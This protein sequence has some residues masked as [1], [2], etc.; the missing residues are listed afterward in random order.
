MLRSVSGSR[1]AQMI[2]ALTKKKW[3]IPGSQKQ[4]LSRS[5][6][7]QWLKE[8]EECTKVE[9][10][11]LDA[12]RRDKG[13]FPSLSKPQKESLLVW[14]NQN[15]YRTVIQLREELL[16]HPETSDNVPST[17]TISRY[18]RAMGYSRQQ[19]LQTTE[20][21]PTKVRLSFE[22]DYPQQL[23]QADT[24]G[25]KVKVPNPDNPNE[26]IYATPIVIV[27]DHSRFCVAVHY[28]V[29]ENEE[30]VIRAVWEAIATYG[31]PETLY[32]DLGGPYR[33]E[34]LKQSL[35]LLGCIVKPTEADSPESK[36]KVEKLMPI[37]SNH[38]ESELLLQGQSLTLEELNEQAQALIHQEYHKTVHGATKETP[39][40]RFFSLPD[41]YRRFVSSKTLSLIFLPHKTAKVSKVGLITFKNQKY[42]VPNSSLYNKTVVIRY[43]PHNLQTI[44]VWYEDTLYGEASITHVHN[45]FRQKQA[46]IEQM[47]QTP[48]SPTLP[49]IS[50]VPMYGRMQ[51]RLAAHRQGLEEEHTNIELQKSKEERGTL[52]K[53]LTVKA[54]VKPQ[55]FDP[56][57]ADACVFLFETILRY[58]LSPSQRT[59]ILA[60]WRRYGPFTEQA[61]R[62][63]LATLL[64]TS[65]PVFDIEAY[66]QELITQKEDNLEKGE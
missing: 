64:A 51:R 53:E 44:F 58:T 46:M 28:V 1:R 14:R 61:V 24:K 12:Q 23:W 17:S 20:Q 45:D 33:G 35:L 13:T 39:E 7:Y 4:T 49:S 62:T 52:K 40:E 47:K 42:L 55:Q 3:T 57:N 60:A 37:F 30:E 8:Y 5:S 63:S 16:Y 66:I 27:D 22:A 6:I 56:F 11:F 9:D 36:G 59:L 21:V 25:P 10:L 38:L 15:P 65:H 31:V 2:E 50:A 29:H 41:T 32:C 43:H 54:S 18:L 48:S 34:R 19:L 26:E